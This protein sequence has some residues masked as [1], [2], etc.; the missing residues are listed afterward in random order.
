MV[1]AIRGEDQGVEAALHSHAR[2][3]K[4]GRQ[5]D[6]GDDSHA[7]Q[8][9][10]AL[11]AVVGWAAAARRALGWP[12]ARVGRSGAATRRQFSWAPNNKIS[13]SAMG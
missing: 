11:H 7:C 8:Q 3:A 6:G 5:G 12:G 9:A 13:T 10:A 1:G 2:T 4:N